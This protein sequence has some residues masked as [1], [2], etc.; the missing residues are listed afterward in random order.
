VRTEFQETEE[1]STYLVAFVICDF[2]YIAN[3]T[4]TNTTVREA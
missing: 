4:K 1:M 3:Q 2:H